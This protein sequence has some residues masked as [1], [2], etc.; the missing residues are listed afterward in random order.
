MTGLGKILLAFSAAAAAFTCA[1]LDPARYAPASLLSTGSWRKV[2]VTSSGMHFIPAAK[3]RE[4]GFSDPMA[5]TLHGYGAIAIPNLLDGST[6]IDDLPQVACERT[7]GGVYFYATG[8][9]R[10]DT[11]EARF[12]TSLNPYTQKGYYFITSGVEKPAEVRREG[13]SY[14]GGGISGYTAVVSYEKDL[15]S[16]GNTG[17][18]FF[19]DD[20]RFTRRRD[21]KFRLPGRVPGTR[22]WV[23]CRVGARSVGSSIFTLSVNGVKVGAANLPPTDRH[24]FGTAAEITAES[25]AEG[26]EVT[27]TLEFT[28]SGTVTA[29]NLDAIDINYTSAIAMDGTAVEFGAY[30]TSAELS[31]AADNLR[32]WDVTDPS[33]PV[34]MKLTALPSGKTGWLNDYTGYRRYTAWTPSLSLPCPADEGKV[35]NSNLHSMPVPELLVITTADLEPQARRYAELRRSA[36]IETA[37][38]VQDAVFNEFSSGSPDPGAFRRLA[39]CLYDRGGSGASGLRYITLFGR[40]AFDNRG[41]TASGAIARQGAMPSW[42]SAESLLENYS[43]TTDDFLAF[44][45]DGSGLHPGSDRY[46]VAVGRIPARNLTEAKVFV[47]KLEKYMAGDGGDW[48]NRVTVCADDGDNGVHML[49]SDELIAAMRDGAS[50]RDMV[51]DKVYI[52]AYPLMG[53]V[54]EE[55]RGRLHRLL[56][57]GTRWWTYTGHANRY[58]LSAQGIMTLTDLNT[59]Q[60]KRWPVFFGATCYFMQWDGPDHTGAEKMFFRPGAGVIAAITA[61]RPVF[62]TENSMLSRALGRKAFD[63]G[64]DGESLALGEMLRQAKNSLAGPAGTSDLNKLKYALM[65]DPALKVAPGSRSIRVTEVDTIPVSAADTADIVLAG[66]A[67][68]LVRGII[69]TPGGEHDKSFNGTVSLTLYDAEKSTLSSGRNIDGTDGARIVFEEH[70]ERLSIARDSVRNGCFEVSLTVPSDLADNYRPALMSLTATSAGDRAAGTFD[71]FYVYGSDPLGSADSVPPVI[72]AFYANHPSFVSGDRVNLTPVIF[73]RVSDNV[74]VNMSPAGIGRAMVLRLDGATSFT[75]VADFFTPNAGHASSGLITYPLPEL[76]PGRHSLTLR[77]T[78]IAGNP[79][80]ATIDFIADP[81]AGPDI[82]EVYTDANP[83]SVEANFY[84]SHNRPDTQMTVSVEVYSLLGNLV[85]SKT[86]T[87]RSE[88]FTTAPITWNLHNIAGQRV[89]RGIYVYRARITV[90]GATVLSRGRRIAVTG[91]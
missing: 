35:A 47:D 20:F 9:R 48:I 52:D 6:Y 71:K 75:D 89:T 84:I 2:S 5:V 85:W 50:G 90:D 79:A 43:Y 60:N 72:D 42:Q 68:A 69:T 80:D 18:R 38:A 28:G 32:V 3:L 27:L 34:A 33:A 54:C 24:S 14:P 81:A 22:L 21:Y 4:W 31:G 41:V 82:Y 13:R 44:L 25:D 37:V 10:L 17:T 16:Y 39:K 46:C 30:T 23:S 45:E 86:V 67:R 1:A 59:L 15:V 76:A 57:S 55:G 12:T 36:G 62:I 58:Y 26:E 87:D 51:Y 83:A 29:A 61:T 74:A 70:G 40:P 11:S 63:T 64:A 66:G 7:P 56:D 73:A 49:Q 8:P 78:D 91:R 53:G 77:I 88:M 65:G 19:G